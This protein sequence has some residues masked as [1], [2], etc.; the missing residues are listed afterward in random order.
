MFIIGNALALF[1]FIFIASLGFV[2]TSAKTAA[3]VKFECCWTAVLGALQ[4]VLIYF[5]TL[6]FVALSYT[7]GYGAIWSS[8]VYDAPW[9][10]R[11]HE[12][13]V[14]L[15]RPVSL[16]IPRIPYENPVFEAHNDDQEE[17]DLRPPRAPFTFNNF[18]NNRLSA[19]SSTSSRPRMAPSPTT[20]NKSF[21]PS[22]AKKMQVQRGVQN[23]F[24]IKPNSGIVLPPKVYM[25]GSSL[26]PP[27]P[28]KE[29][30]PPAF[31]G[32]FLELD[33]HRLSYMHFPSDILDPDQ[34]IQ[35]SRLSS[36]IRADEDSN[37]HYVPGLRP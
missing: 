26:P 30:P 13:N 17:K 16:K 6:S 3:Q 23:P 35:Q 2:Q 33:L 21:R 25:P 34:P 5:L 22:W 27:V 15:P 8:T 36:W 1:F 19:L 32:R 20:S 24:P 29:F 14:Y 31:N 28:P 7:S 9:Y 11:D 37:M 10:I 18:V 4:L 12:P